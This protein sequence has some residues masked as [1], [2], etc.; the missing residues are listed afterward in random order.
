MMPIIKT[1]MAAI[2]I[3]RVW[4]V[5]GSVEEEVQLQQMYVKN[6]LLDGHPMIVLILNIV[7]RF[8]E[9]D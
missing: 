2:M 5:T 6:D 8:A 1:A 7:L 4:K 3:D 9:M